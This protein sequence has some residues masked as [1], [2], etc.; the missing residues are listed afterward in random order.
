[1][2]LE[3]KVSGRVEIIHRLELADA[4][5]IGVINDRFNQLESNMA[6][7]NQQ[8]EQKFNELADAAQTI[9][10][11]Q[12]DMN[13]QFDKVITEVQGVIDS[14][15]NMANPSPEALAAAER[16]TAAIQT[17][18]SAVDA[19]SQKLQ[20]LDDKIPDVVLNPDPQPE[21]SNG[22]NA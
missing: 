3:V 21:P 22:D 8:F 17:V 5:I 10:Q 14:V 15:N 7:A 18:R 4:L 1:M 9:A 2:L 6:T 19:S 12:V 16:A 20:Q 11:G 13:V